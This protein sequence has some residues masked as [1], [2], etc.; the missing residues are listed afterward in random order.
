MREE[1]D[2]QPLKVTLSPSDGEEMAEH[3]NGRHKMNEIHT[4][5][6]IDGTEKS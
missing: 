6:D 5:K 1:N 2:C 3:K 4:K